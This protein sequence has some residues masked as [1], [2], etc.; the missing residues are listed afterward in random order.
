MKKI[1]ILSASVRNGRNSHRV[2][3]YFKNY[4]QAHQLA[5]VS[6]ID[7]N[8]Y[9]FPIFEERLRFI[10]DPS[11]AMLRFAS[12]IT[13]AEGIIIV[14]PEYNGGYPASLKNVIDL[15][16]AEWKRKPLAIAT[17]SA[18]AFA[19]S[20]V[21]TSLQFS[22]WKIGALVVPAMFPVPTIDKTFNEHGEP[23]DKEGT[24]KRANAFV[25][26]LLY[27]MDAKAKMG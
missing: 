18:G 24:D 12:Q 23:A 13:E 8:E 16:Y 1:A 9:D 11:E 6:L 25:S 26:E 17:V 14:T 19:G 4:L 20:Q 5:E 3:L 7:L 2:T 15:L 10:P 22:L 21:I 27:W